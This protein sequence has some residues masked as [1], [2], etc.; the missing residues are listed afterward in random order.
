[1]NVEE[2]LE[3]YPWANGVMVR[4]GMPCVRCGEPFWGTVGELAQMDGFN[5]TEV[6]AAL[7]EEK[8]RRGE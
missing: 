3:E 5:V 2:L 6:I 4:L 1:M 7:N 8:K